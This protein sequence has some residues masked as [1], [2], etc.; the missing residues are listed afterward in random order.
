MAKF[1]L[2]FSKFK[3]TGGDQHHT[4][5]ESPEGHSIKIAH[6]A[7][8]P[9]MREQLH[10]LQ[11]VPSAASQSM[12]MQRMPMQQP[13]ADGG[14]V[15]ETNMSKLLGG[16]RKAFNGED[17]PSK[18]A[19]QSDSASIT[20][21]A[22]A[23]QSS[24]APT[25]S[26]RDQ[27][28]GSIR[29]AFKAEGGM[30]KEYAEGTPDVEQ[31]AQQPASPD[32]SQ[33]SQQLQNMQPPT[34]QAAQQAPQQPADLSQMSQQVQAMQ[35]PQQ[36]Q[37]A[38]P[39]DEFTKIGENAEKN[40]YETSTYQLA[41]AADAQKA[42]DQ[43][44]DHIKNLNDDYQSF[45]DDVQQ[46]HIDPNRYMANKSTLGKIGTVLS[47][48]LG[49]L[50]TI[51]GGRNVALDM[52]NRSIDQDI[53]AQ[54]AELGKR[55]NLL[56]A[57]MRQ[58][59]NVRDAADMSRIMAQGIT[60][61]HLQ[62]LQAQATAP[63]A[64]M[65]AQAMATQL[66]NQI[67]TGMQQL[68][69]RRMLQSGNTNLEGMDP[70]QLVP[71]IVPEAHQKD[72]LHEISQAQNAA[73][74]GD[75]MMQNF[76]KATQENTIAGRIGRA[77]FAPPSIL[78]MRALALPMIHDAEGRVNEFEQKTLN[79]LEPKPG[80][81]ESTIAAKK[82]ALRAFLDQKAS[83]PTA[84]SYGIDL[85]KFKSTGSPELRLP[86]Q[87]QAMVQ[88]ARANPNNPNAQLVLKKLGVQ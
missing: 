22:P 78:T 57:N 18:P 39:K 52:L 26:K 28:L 35:P 24:S 14:D 9:K 32:L 55:E 56:S 45:V 41:R 37:P 83:A 58:Y 2:D 12:P 85:N 19:P 30:I 81:K 80:D 82:Q 76:D 71:S 7:L 66:Q 68:G 25:G 50:G 84:K 36:Q 51:N 72:V 3:K 15:E 42:A 88:W 65:Q 43:Y 5:L 16:I 23:P 54:K 64:K 47:V 4:V 6:K 34:D 59:G 31:P 79:D 20:R 87:Q 40:A 73:H 48:A 74:N 61:Q 29:D 33:M 11:S 17:A 53:D 70:A 1:P 10:K 13:M 67:N 38:P 8:S 21:S 27:A 69:M 75:I 49:G 63:M 60:L 86:P 62:A 77:G 44:Q 46:Q